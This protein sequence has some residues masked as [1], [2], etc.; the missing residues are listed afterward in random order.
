MYVRTFIYLLPHAY[1]FAKRERERGAGSAA[2]VSTSDHRDLHDWRWLC[3]LSLSLSPPLT[4]THIHPV[5]LDAGASLRL[6]PLAR[7][8]CWIARKKSAPHRADYFDAINYTPAALVRSLSLRVYVCLVCAAPP[9]TFCN[10]ELL[11]LF[12]C[13]RVYGLFQQT[14]WIRLFIPSF[15]VGFDF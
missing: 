7:R 2:A 5:S 14:E 1:C 10:E 3:P 11:M 8:R 13:S 6:P 9:A 4:H 15:R 12:F